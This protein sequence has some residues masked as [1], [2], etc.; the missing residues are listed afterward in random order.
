MSLELENDSCELIV[1]KF[2]LR[3]A[4]RVVLRNGARVVFDGF[5]VLNKVRVV[6]SLSLSLSLDSQTLEHKRDGIS[7]RTERWRRRRR[8]RHVM[9]SSAECT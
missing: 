8:R 9:D 3:G 4:L 1:K 2:E 5:K 7:K 6:F